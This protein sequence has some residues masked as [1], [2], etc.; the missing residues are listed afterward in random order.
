MKFFEL[1][2]MREKDERQMRAMQSGIHS[3]VLG[4][5]FYIF[6]FSEFGRHKDFTLKCER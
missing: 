6:G 2:S 5:N 3:I 1:K 4:E